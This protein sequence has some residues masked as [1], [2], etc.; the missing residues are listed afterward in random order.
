MNRL[1]TLASFGTIIVAIAMLGMG[2][3]SLSPASPDVIAAT[4]VSEPEC[5]CCRDFTETHGG[6]TYPYHD[7]PFGTDIPDEGCAEIFS[8]P[9]G[10]FECSSNQGCHESDVS[11]EC[12][13]EGASDH[14][15]DCSEMGRELDVLMAAS[16]NNEAEVIA[17]VIR[18]GGG[19]I[20]FV[21]DRAAVQISDC[22]SAE[23]I[24]S[25]VSVSEGVVAALRVADLDPM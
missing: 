7:F 12:D 14:H 22:G 9:A 1:F 17:E 3:A 15:D 6:T 25:H 21:P 5:G 4:V 13:W 2:P 8:D 20:R 10:P 24:I 18:S 16:E 23:R 11:L 19:R